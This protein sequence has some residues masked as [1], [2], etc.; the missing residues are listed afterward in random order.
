[1]PTSYITIIGRNIRDNIHR[2]AGTV[3]AP[4]LGLYC[5]GVMSYGLG[6]IIHGDARTIYAARPEAREVCGA[7][8]YIKTEAR[9]ELFSDCV[10]PPAARSHFI[11]TNTHHSKANRALVARSDAAA[12]LAFKPVVSVRGGKSAKAH[13]CMEV[14]ASGTSHVIYAALHSTIAPMPCGARVW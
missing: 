8:I 14:I 10:R 2:D 7:E 5:D 6:A 11:H 3:L 9:I 1:M 4:V 13:M 12:T